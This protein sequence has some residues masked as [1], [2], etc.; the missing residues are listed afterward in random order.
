MTTILDGRRKLLHLYVGLH[1]LLFCLY[2]DDSPRRYHAS[3]QHVWTTERWRSQNEYLRIG[4]T[5][6]LSAEK[7][8]C[9][10][11]IETIESFQ[12]LHVWLWQKQENRWVLTILTYIGG[13]KHIIKYARMKWIWQWRRICIFLSCIYLFISIQ[14]AVSKCDLQT[15]PFHFRRHLF[16]KI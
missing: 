3:F 9:H 11:W 16:L 4:R 15:K 14:F 6:Q 13:V 2:D 12:R 10:G 8:F 1:V 5:A 7:S